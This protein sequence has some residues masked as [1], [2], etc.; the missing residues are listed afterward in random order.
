MALAAAEMAYVALEESLGWLIDETYLAVNGNAAYQLALK[1]R[2]RS[3]I[4]NGGENGG[5]M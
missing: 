1:E 3:E 4:N 2:K 5:V